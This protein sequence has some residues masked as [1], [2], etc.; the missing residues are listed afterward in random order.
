MELGT[1]GTGNPASAYSGSN[2]WDVNLNAGYGNNDLTYLYTPYLDMSNITTG[3]MKFALFYDAETGWDGVIV[4][5]TNDGGVTWNYIP[6]DPNCAR[7]WYN[8]NIPL[9]PNF[10]ALDAWSGP[11]SG[12]IFPSYKLCCLNNVLGNSTAIQFRFTFSSDGIIS[13]NGGATIDD[14][15]ITG[16]NG[17]DVGISVSADVS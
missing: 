10:T 14:F 17:N 2:A 6:N 8:E 1:P 9:Q 4:E 12:W 15:C 11:S 5:Y 13:F 3:E 16:T 7:N